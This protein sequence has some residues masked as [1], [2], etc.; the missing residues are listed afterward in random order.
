MYLVTIARWMTSNTPSL[1]VPIATGVLATLQYSE[2][3]SSACT[4][5][6]SCSSRLDYD[7]LC[8]VSTM[9]KREASCKRQ[10]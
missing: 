1:S 4:A 5:C 10:L 3:Q 9:A 2:A 8:V 6:T 7:R